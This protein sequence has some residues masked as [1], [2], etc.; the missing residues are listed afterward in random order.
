MLTSSL[1]LK[2]S[3]LVSS[4]QMIRPSSAQAE[5]IFVCTHTSSFS[6]KPAP[7]LFHHQSSSDFG[8]LAWRW[9]IR[10]FVKQVA[11]CL[12]YKT[13]PTTEWLIMPP[14]LHRFIVENN[15][16][17]LY[18]VEIV[19]CLETPH[20]VVCCLDAGNRISDE[21]GPGDLHRRWV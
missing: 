9:E 2:V 16:P 10:G 8:F 5:F 13:L 14:L 19:L 6:H 3:D 20:R 12:T 7:Y 15:P 17:D 21:T 18:C 4:P 11:P 1:S